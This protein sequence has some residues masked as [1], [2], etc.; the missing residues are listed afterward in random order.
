VIDWKPLPTGRLSRLTRMAGVGARIGLSLLAS[1]DAGAAA[2]AHAAEVLGTLRGLAA[3]VGQMAS[4]V[5]GMVP[6]EHRA[7]YGK[8][9]ET[10]RT[11]SPSSSPEA[12]ARTVEEELGA[13]LERLFASFEREP[14][15]SASVGQVH[16]AEL[17]DGRA[18]AVKVQH[19]GIDRAVESDLENAA[20]IESLISALGPRAMDAGSV[21]EDVRARFREELDY[22]LEAERQQRFAAFFAADARVVVPA[23]VPELSARRVLTSEFVRGLSL[24]EAAGGSEDERRAHAE[25]LW[26]F[27]FRTVLL[28]GLFNADPHPGNYLFQ[29]DGRVAFLDFGCVQPLTEQRRSAALLMHTGAAQRDEARFREGAVRV[30]QTRGGSYERAALG[31]VRT[32]FRPLFESPFTI[33]GDYVAELVNGIKKLKAEMFAKDKSFVMPPPGTAFMNRLQFG[34]YSVLARLDVAVD[35]AAVEREFLRRGGI[36]V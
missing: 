27:A 11:A 20:V 32:C 33:R 1:R 17:F 18:V 30:L 13:P 28:L 29:A 35:Y 8:A 15:A 6:A 22:R 25:T 3:K 9:L 26:H 12:V 36:A 4:Y 19:P 14:F 21:F 5:E 31:Y 10:L 23:V 2:A 24:E 34:F 16:R 7:A